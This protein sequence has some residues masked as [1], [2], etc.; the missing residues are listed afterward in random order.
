[1]KIFYD[2]TKTKPRKLSEFKATKSEGY[3]LLPYHFEF[4]KV[5]KIIEVTLSE[6]YTASYDPI[7]LESMFVNLT[8][9]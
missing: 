3:F 8:P 5:S 1:M 7:K 2:S 4:R 6:N 9:G